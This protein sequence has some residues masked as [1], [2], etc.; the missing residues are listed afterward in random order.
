MT[1]SEL[2]CVDSAHV[3]VYNAQARLCIC[4]PAGCN[5]RSVTLKKTEKLMKIL[6]QSCLSIYQE[7]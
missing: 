2:L 6:K 4:L 5:H 7:S 1:L 3:E